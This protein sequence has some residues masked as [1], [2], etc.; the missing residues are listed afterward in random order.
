MH[1]LIDRHG[2]GWGGSDYWWLSNLISWLLIAALVALAVILTLRLA[3]RSPLDG[4][5]LSR[6]GPEFD[7]AI[8]ELRLRYAR[9][10]V[11]R[12]EYLR[13]AGDL[14]A[15]GARPDPPSGQS[16]A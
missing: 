10:E 2:Y 8:S 15:P 12:D 7:P 6:S 9:G 16:P 14:G 4:T 5:T 13:V 1:H 11:S 3:G